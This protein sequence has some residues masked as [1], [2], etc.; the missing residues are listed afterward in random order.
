MLMEIDHIVE[1]HIFSLFI[2]TSTA[3][4]LDGR[5]TRSACHYTTTVP[6]SRL[7]QLFDVLH[8]ACFFYCLHFGKVSLNKEAWFV[9]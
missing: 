7:A 6:S 5:D 1:R 2:S 3:I 8:Y 9:A 4:Y